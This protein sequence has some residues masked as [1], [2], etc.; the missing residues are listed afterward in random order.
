MST[1]EVPVVL[2]DAVEKHPHADRLELGLGPGHAEGR[3]PGLLCRGERTGY[4]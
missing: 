3:Q 1:F 2:L 4:E